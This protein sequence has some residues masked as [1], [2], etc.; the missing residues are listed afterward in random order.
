[1]LVSIVID[2]IFVPGSLAMCSGNFGGQG[3]NANS[4]SKSWPFLSCLI[5]LFPPLWR[6]FIIQKVDIIEK[7]ST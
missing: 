2:Q 4:L 5:F 3:W 6:V 7:V 1:M